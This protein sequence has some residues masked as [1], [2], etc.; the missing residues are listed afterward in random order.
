MQTISECKQEVGSKN[1]AHSNGK[2]DV[3]R[4]NKK[5][6]VVR[7]APLY[8]SMFQIEVKQAFDGLAQLE[9]VGYAQAV[10]WVALADHNP[11]EL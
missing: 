9:P 4:T 1:P 5:S 11:A 10:S 6:V 2:P 3:I 7:F 8:E